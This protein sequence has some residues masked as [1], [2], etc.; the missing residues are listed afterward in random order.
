MSRTIIIAIFVS[1]IQ[2]FSQI[3]IAPSE[4]DGTQGSPYQ[5][6]SLENL[7]WLASSPSQMDKYYIQTADI[8]ASDTVTWYI[9]DHDSVSYTGDRYIGWIQIG[10]YSESPFTGSYDGQGYVISNLYFSYIDVPYGGT[11]RQ[12]KGL[13]GYVRGAE[14]KNVRLYN[15]D[16]SSMFYTGGIV[17]ENRYGSINNCYVE[18]EID[19]YTEGGGIAGRNDGGIISNCRTDINFIGSSYSGGIVG[20]CFG[21]ALISNCYSTGSILT[22]EDWSGGLIGKISDSDVINCYSAVY[23][24]SSGTDCG[25]LIG[26]NNTSTFTSSFWDTE[27]SGQAASNG[28]TGKTT[29]EMRNVSTFTDAGWDFIGESVNGTED[30]WTIGNDYNFGYPYF[31]NEE[32]QSLP[33]VDTYTIYNVTSSGAEIH[34]LLTSPGVSNVTQYGICWNTSGDP[35]T[36]DNFTNDGSTDTYISYTSR[37]SGLTNGTTYFAR[38]YAENSTGISYGRELKFTTLAITPVEP[39]GS[40]TEIDPYQIANLE[41]LYWITSDPSHFGYDYIQTADIDASATQSW[42]PDSTKTMKGWLPIGNIYQSFTGVYNGQDFDI[43]NLYVNRPE[44]DF[45]GLFARLSNADVKFM[46]IVDAKVTGNEYTGCVV[47]D[48]T[49]SDLNYNTVSGTISGGDMTG[50]MAG[51]FFEYSGLYNSNFT[52]TVNGVYKCGGLIGYSAKAAV[53]FSSSAANVTGKYSYVGG[54]IGHNDF[55]DVLSSNASGTVNGYSYVGGLC[56]HSNNHPIYSFNGEINDCFSRVDVKGTQYVGGILGSDSYTKITD[57]NCKGNVTAFAYAGGLIGSAYS[58]ELLYTYFEG[59]VESNSYTGGLIGNAIDAE[60]NRSYNTGTVKGYNYAG[61][62][63]GVSDTSIINDSYNIGYVL[64]ESYVGGLTGT[65][66]YSTSTNC[67]SSGEV[68]GND[69]TGGFAGYDDSSIF[70]SSFWNSE[71]SGQVTSGGGISLTT[72]EMRTSD[73]FTEAGWDLVTI[74]DIDPR[75]NFGFPYLKWQEIHST[76][77]VITVNIED[78]TTT[79]VSVKGAIVNLGDSNPTQY[80]FCWNETGEPTLADNFIELGSI[81]T[82]GIFIS[83][84]TDL[85]KDTIYYIRAYATNSSGTNYGTDIV[86]KTLSTEPELPEGGGTLGNP[87]VVSNLGNLYWITL[88][89]ERWDK[90]YIQDAWINASETSEWNN[91]KGWPSIGNIT[92]KF[93]GSYDGGNFAIDGLVIKRTSE[94]YIGFFGYVE[95]GTLNNIL[96]TNIEVVGSSTYTGG[97]AGALFSSSEVNNCCCTGSVSSSWYVGGLVGKSESSVITKSFTKGSVEGYT[98]TGGLVGWN[99]TSE[100]NDSF[101]QSSV[102]GKYHETN[103]QIGGLVGRHNAGAVINNCY[104]TGKVTGFE[105]VGGFI[106]TV[107]DGDVENSY[108]DT[109]TSGMTTSIAGIGKKT[110]EMKT[111]STFTDSGWDFQGETVNGTEDIW[112]IDPLSNDGYPYLWWITSDIED[113]HSN[114]PNEITLYQNYP[115]PFNPVTKI[116]FSIPSMRNVKLSVY[117]SNGQLVD[118]LENRK[119]SK[120]S[121]SVEFNGDKLNSGIYFYRLEAEGMML[122][123]KMLLIK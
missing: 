118:V 5:I 55:S 79:S 50:G 4:G 68:V 29:A 87:Y 102:I 99:M 26:E 88:D 62:L 37:I 103:G 14:I 106:G 83:N 39:A 22:S 40:G 52:G 28:G 104:S 20:R 112:D 116:S 44:E 85:L 122:T 92:A 42:Y 35:T 16:F 117:N 120:G 38:A 43:T 47:G 18:G 119:F 94:S 7:F 2:L 72:T 64:G 48:A 81:D 121:H 89:T 6:A 90:S 53:V 123:R 96:L 58:S 19:S 98:L 31:N 110:A 33:I 41:N 109:E 84:V 49:G 71:T 86:F 75:I 80:G 107:D 66:Y 36:A 100:I 114:I 25:G 51:G 15:I 91:G 93:T 23:I 21:G 111:L 27:I 69:H 67:Y 115:N 108:W 17:G 73:T 82:T 105:N 57:T 76:P 12:Q 78:K 95:N 45:V 1:V 77:L 61:G 70:T 101:S 56:G 11:D 46:N 34:S 9:E 8:D 10:K 113:D 13:F 60:I 63:I 54:L 65:F 74:W 3:A 30:I 24:T 59:Y 97:L 32:A